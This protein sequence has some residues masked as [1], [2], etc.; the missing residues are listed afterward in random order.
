MSFRIPTS[1]LVNYIGAI[2]KPPY[3]PPEALQGGHAFWA[4]QCDMWACTITLWNLVTGLRLYCWP[5]PSD[6]IFRYAIM[7]QGLSPQYTNEFVERVLEETGPTEF[8]IIA[9]ISQEILTLSPEL[10]E[11]F[12]G[13]LAMSPND[14]WTM[15]QVLACDWMTMPL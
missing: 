1:G 3:C 6:L 7:A 12:H 4:R 15:E 11:L 8:I 2:G 9:Q 5:N 10:L 14:R 13:V